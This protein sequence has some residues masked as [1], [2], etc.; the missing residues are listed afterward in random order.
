[1]GRGLSGGVNTANELSEPFPIGN[2]ATIFLIP[3]EQSFSGRSLNLGLP[4]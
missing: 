1:M 3:W 4:G 2:I